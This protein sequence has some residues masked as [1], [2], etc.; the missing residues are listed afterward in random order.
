MTFQRK[1]FLTGCLAVGLAVG[2][3]GATGWAAEPPATEASTVRY[4]A[5]G[6]RDP[7]IPLVRDGQ[8]IAV[9]GSAPAPGDRPVLYGIL[10]DP[11]GGSLALINDREMQVGDVINGYRV[12]A[13]RQ[14]A[15]VLHVED[16]EPVVLRIE[17]EPAPG[18]SSGATT[19]GAGQ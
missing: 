14:D 17:F 7:F 16:G 1:R 8:I 4:N 2:F 5:K 9:G 10:W 19:G 18:P 15:V 11:G 6:R 3:S 12:T 13:I